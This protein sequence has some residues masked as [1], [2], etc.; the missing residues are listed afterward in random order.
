ML[1][2][3][4][5]KKLCT[6]QNM[7]DPFVDHQIRQENGKKIISYG[8]SSVGYDIRICDIFKEVV[9]GQTIDPFSPETIQYRDLKTDSYV[10]HP[11]HFVLAVSLERFDMPKDVMAIAV[12]KSTLARYGLFPNITPLEPKWRGY[13][14]IEIANLGH[15]PVVIHAGMAIS[16]LLFFRV[17]PEVVYDSNR[18]YQDQGKNVTV[19]AL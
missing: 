15:N 9:G 18:K 14:T 11:G 2:D 12:N 17:H 7:I 3:K 4:E 6:E 8:L 10:L 16:Q 1:S 5:I 13:L 19:A